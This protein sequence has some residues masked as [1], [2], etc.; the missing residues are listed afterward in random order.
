MIE[1]NNLTSFR[2]NKKLLNNSAQKILKD[3]KKQNFELSIALVSQEKIKKLNKK[4]RK[5]NRPTDTLSF[6]YKNSGEIVI[7]PKEVKKNAKNFGSTFEK[8]LVRVLIHGVLHLL[9]Y[10]HEKSKLRAK[11]MEAKEKYYLKRLK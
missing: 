10:D 6:L 7:C 11:K 9:G 5:K 1:I 8:E 2:V 3:K 4:Y